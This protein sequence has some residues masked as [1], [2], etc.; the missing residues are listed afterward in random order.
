MVLLLLNLHHFKA[1]NFEFDLKE[2]TV[3][4]LKNEYLTELKKRILNEV[5]LSDPVVE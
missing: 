5:Y 3:R 2:T 4:R 1:Y